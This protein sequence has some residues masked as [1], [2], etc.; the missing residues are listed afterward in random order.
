MTIKG[1]DVSH[2]QG[3]IDWA[4]VA[5]AGISFAWIKATQGRGLV[6]DRWRTNRDGAAANGIRWGAYHFAAA[7]D[8]LVEAAHFASAG[9]VGGGLPPALDLEAPGMSA[10]WA[11]RFL[12]E[13]ERLLGLAPDSA[14]FYGSA[15]YVG[16][17]SRLARHPLW[18]PRYKSSAVDPDPGSL[19]GPF[20]GRIPG[21]GA[22]GQHVAVWQYT[23]SG[24]VDGIGGNVDRDIVLDEAW[25]NRLVGLEPP[26]IDPHPPI[27][28]E[29]D[30]MANGL[31]C[32]N[33]DG[34]E[35][36]FWLDE[37]GHLKTVWQ[38]ADGWS[39]AA[40]LGGDYVWSELIS[41]RL[42]TGVAGPAGR[43]EVVGLSEFL[44]ARRPAVIAQTAPNGQWSGVLNLG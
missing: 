42:S 34:R 3:S 38:T 30:L 25:W 31:T 5:R 2:H 8:P 23:S 33:E 41:A 11:I 39:G 43:I 21:V 44:G 26:V 36:I 40:S 6:D 19:G 13:L 16:S 17:S 10:D 1:I 7:G 35:Q 32:P 4:K 12:D 14:V 37:H 9:I 24:R 29:N 20:D 18:F 28:Q 15:A 27:S 22:W